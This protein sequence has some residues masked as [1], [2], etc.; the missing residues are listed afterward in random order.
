M[1]DVYGD[2]GRFARIVQER[3]EHAERLGKKLPQE[4]ATI[5]E[6]EMART[7]SR[8]EPLQERANRR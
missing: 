6:Y 5:D 1:S 2:G 3:R 4:Y 8:A 7:Q